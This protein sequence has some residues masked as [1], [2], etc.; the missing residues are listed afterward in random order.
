MSYKEMNPD[1]VLPKE[2]KIFLKLQDELK[3][4]SVED[5][6]KLIKQSRSDRIYYN[7]LKTEILDLQRELN[8]L[9]TIK[10]EKLSS[11]ELFIH[12][13]KFGGNRIDYKL[14]D[15]ECF[16]INLPYTKEKIYIP[17]KYTAYNEK[18]QFYTLYLVDDKEYELFDENNN[19]L[20]NISGTDLEKY[21]LDK[22][23][24]IDKLYSQF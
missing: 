23:K 24:E 7:K 4:H 12:S 9:D 20:K 16:C 1:Y 15:N 10:E 21:V 17:K 8:H 5:A 19:K 18:H 14:S 22:K 13:I 3:I 6:K 11:S 2:T